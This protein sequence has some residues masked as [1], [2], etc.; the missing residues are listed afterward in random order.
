[1]KDELLKKIEDL[2]DFRQ[3]PRNNRYDRST[4]QQNN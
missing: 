1:M 3:T 4:F 2:Y